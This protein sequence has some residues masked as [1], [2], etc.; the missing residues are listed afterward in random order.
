MP[1][2]PVL[3]VSSRPPSLH[4]F[5][6]SV[7]VD[8]FF[9][10]G[11]KGFLPSLSGPILPERHSFGFPDKRGSL[12]YVFFYLTISLRPRSFSPYFF[13]SV[14]SFFHVLFIPDYF[15]CLFW[16][17]L[18]SPAISSVYCEFVKIVSG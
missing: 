7:T 16:I 11:F 13:A 18:E 2:F 4:G 10:H 15:A 5:H 1:G 8:T 6:Q 9:D 12:S 3:L 14:S 17:S